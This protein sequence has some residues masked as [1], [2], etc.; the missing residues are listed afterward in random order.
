MIAIESQSTFLVS[1]IRQGA[2]RA[3]ERRITYFSN[4]K[5]Q[6]FRVFAVAAAILILVRLPLI[7]L[8]PLCVVPPEG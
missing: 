3:D 1:V 2:A 6:L 8:A 7:L 4:T 5:S